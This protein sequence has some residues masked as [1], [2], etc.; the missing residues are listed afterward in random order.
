MGY[1]FP[2]I[3]ALEQPPELLQTDGS[4]DLV[5]VRWPDKLVTFQ[6][7]L[8]QTET[9]A[10]PVQSLDLVSVSI[11]KNVQGAGKGAQAQFEL[12]EHRQTV[13]ALSEVNRFATQIYLI[14]GAAWVHQCAP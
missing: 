14:E 6:A 7:L 12:H 5:C 10:M 9:V 4:G 1:I 2:Q 8:P 13:D 11:G 3:K